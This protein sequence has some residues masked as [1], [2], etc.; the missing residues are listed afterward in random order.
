MA[1]TQGGR[2]I[3]L[4]KLRLVMEAGLRVRLRHHFFSWVQGPVQTMLPHDVMICGVFDDRLRSYR[5]D[6]F[7]CY[8]LS[9]SCMERISNQQNGVLLQLVRAWGSNDHHPLLV[10]DLV[11]PDLGMDVAADF[12]RHRLLNL[13]A[14]GICGPSGPT[15]TFFGFCRI[16]G[17]PDQRYSYMAELLVPILHAAWM[18]TLHGESPHKHG[19]APP[20]TDGRPLTVRE[21][22]ILR[23][24]YEGKSNME[25]GA[26]LG[27]S[28][29]TVK[30]HV[31]NILRKLKVQNRAQA[32]G[33]GLSLDLLRG[34]SR[35]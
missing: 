14:H 11:A 28:G 20:A 26:I 21:S 9:A 17:K 2:D 34:H 12:T 30:N 16:P 1:A 23:W 7:S 25:I 32:V 15:R 6:F 35:S 13:L 24:V 27:I 10:D 3:D 19:S 22:E 18:R 29:L 31:Q 5:V 4:D 8:P 33:K